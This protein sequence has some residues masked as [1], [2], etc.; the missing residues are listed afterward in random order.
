MGRVCVG[1]RLIWRRRN[2]PE[3]P[4]GVTGP[5][6]E[7]VAGCC[8]R[9]GGGGWCLV[10]CVPSGGWCVVEGIDDAAWVTVVVAG[11]ACVHSAGWKDVM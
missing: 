4:S 7:E 9:E 1:G 5:G 11:W 6:R 2:V 10:G 8:W 3:A